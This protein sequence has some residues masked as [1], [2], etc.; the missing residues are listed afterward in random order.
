MTHLHP[1]S[2]LFLILTVVPTVLAYPCPS[3]G[4][5]NPCKCISAPG[6]LFPIDMKCPDTTTE[7]ELTT[8]FQ[9]NFPYKKFRSFYMDGNQ[10]INTLSDTMLGDVVSFKKFQVDNGALTTVESGALE[11]SVNQTYMIHFYQNSIT[12]FPFDLLSQ[13]PMLSELRLYGN[14]ITGFPT[15]SSQS[16]EILSL[17]SNPLGVLPETAFASTP[18]LREIHLY[19]SGITEILPGKLLLSSKTATCYVRRFTSAVKFG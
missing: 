16:L 8:V 12:A 9:A 3:G 13:M 19:G 5:I 18:S 17:G 1:S 14:Q 10:N 7:A 6:G 2:A 15:I 11:P 4:D